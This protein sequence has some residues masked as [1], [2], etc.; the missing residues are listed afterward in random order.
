[1]DSTERLATFV[2]TR[3]RQQLKAYLPEMDDRLLPNAVSYAAIH[4]THDILINIRNANRAIQPLFDEMSSEECINLTFND[5]ALKI[6]SE[7]V[8]KRAVEIV[9]KNE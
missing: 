3:A 7:D 2:A 1:M 9:K 4:A 6:C 8:L 5:I